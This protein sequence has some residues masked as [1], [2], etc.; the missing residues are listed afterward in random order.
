MPSS[1][2]GKPSTDACGVTITEP[3]ERIGLKLHDG[4]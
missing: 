4:T 1:G 2:L 3:H